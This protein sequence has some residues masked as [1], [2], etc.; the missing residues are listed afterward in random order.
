MDL[1]ELRAEKRELLRTMKEA[2]VRRTSCFNG[3]HTPQSYR[4]NFRLF[5]LNTLIGRLSAGA[6]VKP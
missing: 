6:G 5:E 2:G 4:M 1:K 3:G